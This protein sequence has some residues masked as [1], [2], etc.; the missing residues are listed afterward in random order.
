MTLAEIFNS[1]I[2]DLGFEKTERTR[3]GFMSQVA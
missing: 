2:Q 3:I 1:K